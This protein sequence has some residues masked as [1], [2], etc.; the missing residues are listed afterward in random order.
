M[1]EFTGTVGNCAKGT[2]CW[3]LALDQRSVCRAQE[4]QVGRSRQHSNLGRVAIKQ[5]Q[6]FAAGSIEVVIDVFGKVG[7][8]IGVAKAKPR[9]PFAGDMVEAGR[10]KSVVTGLLKDGG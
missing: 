1:S 6:A 2:S 7:A 8:H 5:L 4:T 10:F 3:T 9:S